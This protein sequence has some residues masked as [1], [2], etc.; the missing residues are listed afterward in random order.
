MPLTARLEAVA[1][2]AA[3]A[4]HAVYGG[5]IV[6]SYF[7]SPQIKIHA[8]ASGAAVTIEEAFEAFAA[9]LSEE[10]GVSTSQVS[11]RITSDDAGFFHGAFD[12]NQDEGSPKL[13]F[14][15]ILRAGIK[16]FPVAARVVPGSRV[17][18]R[19]AVVGG[20]A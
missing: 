9:V 15:L 3:D 8:P 12:P 1:Q 11:S 14:I 18:T 2:M 5:D 13:P 20:V 17:R 6:A 10:L 4:F 7:N 16:D 19:R